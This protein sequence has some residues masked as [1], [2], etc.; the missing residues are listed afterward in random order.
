MISSSA[1]PAAAADSSQD[2]DQRKPRV[3]LFQGDSITDVGRDRK[4]QI[5]NHPAALGRGYPF[6]IAGGLLSSHRDADLQIH[7]RGISGNKVPDLQ[8]RWQEDCID[9]KP[10]VLSILIGVNDIWHKLNGR[11]DGTVETYDEGYR[12]LL[13]ETQQQLPDTRIV[14]CEPFVLRCGAVNDKW[15]PEFEQRRQAARKIASDLKLTL[16]PFQEMFDDATT[17]NVPPQY[18]AGDGVHPTIAG[19]ALMAKTWR[20]T[21]GL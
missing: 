12:S 16:V 6:F 14:I 20:D 4:R 17:G 19:H 2:N 21:V 3:I 9:L 1:R 5:A 10:D 18:W 15:F 8:K 7:N 11:Y 13:Q